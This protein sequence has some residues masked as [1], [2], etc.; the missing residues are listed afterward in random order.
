LTLPVGTGALAGTPPYP[1]APLAN[2]TWHSEEFVSRIG[3]SHT[4]VTNG[5]ALTTTPSETEPLACS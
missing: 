5:V 2:S 1:L 3:E 4:T